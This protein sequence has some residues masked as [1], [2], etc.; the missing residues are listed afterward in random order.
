MQLHPSD[1]NHPAAP[2]VRINQFSA[3]FDTPEL[4]PVENLWQF[5]CNR[6]LSNQIFQ[7]YSDILDHC[8]KAWNKII[9]QRCLIMSI[10]TRRWAR[11]F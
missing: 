6:W 5:L 1:L 8:C 10:G 7:P 3:L 4:N 11:G 9:A 2:K